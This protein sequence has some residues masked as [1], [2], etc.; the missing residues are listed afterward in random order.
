MP[1]FLNSEFIAMV[2]SLTNVPPIKPENNEN[3]TNE[4]SFKS[5]NN[6]NNNIDQ[7]QEIQQQSSNFDDDHDDDDDDAM[8]I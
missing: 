8:M 6:N 1:K 4:M 2:N 7:P 3:K 5:D